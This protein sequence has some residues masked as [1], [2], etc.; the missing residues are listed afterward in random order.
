[1][2][3]LGGGAHHRAMDPDAT[4]TIPGS[5]ASRSA[6]RTL[7]RC[8]DHRMLAG[9]AGGIAD[10]F[11]VDVTTVRI[12]IVALCV[13]GGAGVP[14]Y[15]A[16]WLLVPEEGMDHSIADDLLDHAGLR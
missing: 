10:Y 15:L 3:L 2:A 14:L 5:G 12:A 1:M 6:H 8:A 9:V 13:L 4:T 16:A 7:R 11:D